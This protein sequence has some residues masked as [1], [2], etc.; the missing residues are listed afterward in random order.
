M[1]N[2]LLFLLPFSCCLSWN[3]TIYIDHT[4]DGFSNGTLDFPLK[5]A[6][7]WADLPS[8]YL[9]YDLDVVFLTFHH[10][11]HFSWNLSRIHSI[12]FTSP[13]NHLIE[14][15]SNNPSLYFPSQLCSCD[16]NVTNLSVA[17]IS[18]NKV[19]ATDSILLTT[20]H[21]LELRLYN[22]SLYNNEGD[23][24]ICNLVAHNC[25]NIMIVDGSRVYGLFLSSVLFFT[26][27]L[28]P[29]HSIHVS[30]A[31]NS[32]YFFHVE[33]T[34]GVLCQTQSVE[35]AMIE[36]SFLTA[37]LVD[38]TSSQFPLQVTIT[39]SVLQ[40]IRLEYLQAFDTVSI[41]NLSCSSLLRLSGD[42]TL[43]LFDVQAN[44]AQLEASS[45]FLLGCT[46]RGGDV[47]VRYSTITDL[48]VLS[49]LSSFCN[50]VLSFS[51]YFS[52]S[53][54]TVSTGVT[55][56]IGVTGSVQINGLRTINYDC[57]SVAPYF[58]VRSNTFNLRNSVITNNVPVISFVPR[59]AEASFGLR[60]VEVYQ[61]VNPFITVTSNF[62]ITSF[63]WNSRFENSSTSF[64][65][66]FPSLL[67]P[68]LSVTVY[69]SQF[70]NV[71]GVIYNAVGEV[72]VI[73][74]VIDNLL[75]PFI[76]SSLL[77]TVPLEV[78]VT[79]SLFS[80]VYTSHL[81]V[82]HKSPQ[83]SLTLHHINIFNSTFNNVVQ[84]DDQLVE[85]KI[86][87]VM[88][89]YSHFQSLIHSR[90]G[91]VNASLN[92]LTVTDCSTTFGLIYGFTA[93]VYSSCISM[94][95]VDSTGTLLFR[96]DFNLTLFITNYLQV[97][98]SSCLHGLVVS[99]VLTLSSISNN[100]SILIDNFSSDH[101]AVAFSRSLSL[102]LVDVFFDAAV[103]NTF[104]SVQSATV[105]ESIQILA[106][107][108]VSTVPQSP[109]IQT[110]SLISS[111][112]S[113]DCLGNITNSNKVVRSHS[114][115]LLHSRVSPL[116]YGNH[117]PA[118]SYSLECHHLL[119]NTDSESTIP[120]PCFFV[121]NHSLITLSH[122]PWIYYKFNNISKVLIV[123][124][125][126][127]LHIGDL[128][129]YNL[130]VN[131]DKFK[132]GHVFTLEATL[133]NT[134]HTLSYSVPFCIAGHEFVNDQCLACPYGKI[135]TQF[136]FS[137]SCLPLD[138]SRDVA[139]TGY[140]YAVPRSFFVE[141]YTIRTILKRCVKPQFCVGGLVTAGFSTASLTVLPK[142]LTLESVFNGSTIRYY[143][144]CAFMHY[145]SHCSYCEDYWIPNNAFLGEATLS[146]LT[147][148]PVVRDF[149][150]GTC[151]V[152]LPLRNLLVSSLLLLFLSSF[153]L[154][155]VFHG[156]FRRLLLKFIPVVADSSLRNWLRRSF[157]IF[158]PL[159]TNSLFSFHLNNLSHETLK[160]QN[161]QFSPL[162]IVLC[163]ARYS[164]YS[165]DSFSFQAYIVFI[166]LLCT[167]VISLIIT[168]YGVRYFLDR[169]IAKGNFV[170]LLKANTVFF[171]N[172]EYVLFLLLPFMAGFA[173]LPIFDTLGHWYNGEEFSLDPR[174]PGKYNLLII[175]GCLIVLTFLAAYLLLLPKFH[176]NILEETVYKNQSARFDLLIVI[177][178]T[179]LS[180]SGNLFGHNI[181]Y[182]LLIYFV[183]VLFLLMFLRP[184]SIEYFNDFS[185]RIVT[186][187][188]LLVIVLSST[189]TQSR[190]LLS[191]TTLSIIPIM[192]WVLCMKSRSQGFVVVR[193]SNRRIPNQQFSLTIL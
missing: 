159:F 79:S 160:P 127:E 52:A 141:E 21:I 153:L 101:T 177:G 89:N 99:D 97:T 74:S 108:L 61:I 181:V 72:K 82:V 188:L 161:I 23:S 57:D 186:T 122:S 178:R 120:G 173:A 75:G 13:T 117:P 27:H 38:L 98:E 139:Y 3:E 162:H 56:R 183:C 182:L 66:H 64:I 102:S 46:F 41:R 29:I 67:Y 45:M 187:L 121:T 17:Q 81:F 151:V 171:R 80:H 109:I 24:Q 167:V 15:P 170:L 126:N 28:P 63:I 37:V 191:L 30:G 53:R 76:E 88:I 6:S 92:T 104:F 48:T 169:R 50:N 40:T 142:T 107:T 16:I 18:A 147:A 134:T 95:N 165:L 90:N 189:T 83:F 85:V 96:G 105:L 111:R 12:H 47:D 2:F 25:R 152:C 10:N 84:L 163:F 175:I 103:Y 20:G 192:I 11:E 14:Q 7:D 140:L 51:R 146:S 42:S 58:H 124:S 133:F 116:F 185:A 118:L 113:L 190:V 100:A 62:F 70:L 164:H 157:A 115:S 129:Y 86:E 136:N 123:D 154:Y 32:L 125:T 144:G 110:Y 22:S 106:G 8:E 34:L 36:F 1:L 155:A 39:N 172:L 184:F 130:P 119:F 69:L 174:Y 179:L 138:T 132:R 148:R 149:A 5:S 78:M 150:S 73:D 33:D 166:I 131:L 87:N 31:S 65:F 49:D 43:Q 55:L 137:G 35:T 193:Q 128:F 77:S 19:V 9:V 60:N 44:Q 54:L 180:V 112:G 91:L 26:G 71:S 135:Q 168:F 93:V 145:G 158:L 156:S 143:S 114:S 59:T 68:G 94:S 176:T 4:Y